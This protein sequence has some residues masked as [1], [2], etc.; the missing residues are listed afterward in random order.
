MMTGDH[1]DSDFGNLKVQSYLRILPPTASPNIPDTVLV[2]DSIRMDLRFNYFF[3]DSPSTHQLFVHELTEQLD[4][5]TT[6][7]SFDSTPFEPLSVVDST[8]T[9]TETDTLLSID[10]EMMKDELFT[11]LKDFVPDS[12][13]SA[14]FVEQ[15]KGF[16]LISDPSSSAVMGFD[17][18]HSQSNI[19]LYYTTNDTVVNTVDIGY[20]T[21]YNQITPDYTGTELEGIQLL[22]DFTPIS[23]R[24]Y[25]Q[26]GTGLVPKVDFQSFFDFVDN[27]TTGTIVINKAELK[28]DNLQGLTGAI[29]P[30]EEMS[31]YYTNESNGIIEVGEELILPGT[32][33][34]DAVYNA[35]VRNNLDPQRANARSVRAALDT[36]NVEFRPEITLFLQ[37]VADGALVRSDVSKVLSIPYSFVEIPRSVFDNGR[38]VDRF[39]VEPGNLR[40][41]LFYTRLK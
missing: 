32:I 18:T 20:S 33:Q 37:L 31:F 34:T 23:G 3:G 26:V 29:Q 41:E 9:V 14:E 11:A 35:A 4:P 1:T 22:T 24:N 27:D 7:F 21:Y 15:F 38:N 5:D 19:T 30:P 2:A 25:M 12:A 17:N 36:A 10:L 40:L 13:G 39:I 8:F 6:Y 16:T 28:M